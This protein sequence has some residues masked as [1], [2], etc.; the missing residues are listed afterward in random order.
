MTAQSIFTQPPE[1]AYQKAARETVE[2]VQ[3]VR[4]YNL[5]ALREG[6]SKT[7]GT[8]DH[9][10]VMDGLGTN[11]RAFVEV[12]ERYIAWISQE[13]TINN[14]TAGLADLAAIVARVPDYAKNED[15]TVTITQPPE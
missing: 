11:A 6:V 3:G 4:N 5:F 13:L 9:Q 1:T 10:A 7:F 14:D 2:T 12:Y 15:G 8:D